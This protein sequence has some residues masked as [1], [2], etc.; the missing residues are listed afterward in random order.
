LTAPTFVNNGALSLTNGVTAAT[1][2]TINGAY[3]AQG[4]AE[5]VLN[6]NGQQANFLHIAGLA[7]GA[8]TVVAAP[9][10]N[11]P[12]LFNGL[13]PFVRDNGGGATFN[14]ANGGII[15]GG[16]SPLVT[17]AITP[18]PSNPNQYD[19]YSKVNT[20]AVAPVAGSIS[21][22]IGSVTT[23][24]FQGTTAFL[25]QPSNPTPNQIDGGV[26]TRGATGM[27][28][29]S[30]V[31]TTSLV[32]NP[33]DLQIKSHFSGYQVGSDLGMFNI[34][35]SGWNLHAGITGGEYVAST[36]GSGFVA[37]TPGSGFN[38]GW[39][40]YNVPFLGVY[41]AAT[42]HGFFADAVYRHDFWQGEVFNQN[43][44]LTNAP[45]SGGNGNSVTVE[46]GYN[47]RFQNGILN[48]ITVTPS[49]GFNYTRVTFNPLTLFP[50]VPTTSTA[51]LNLGAVESDLG[52][53]GV[54]VSDTFVTPYFALSPNATASVWHEFAGPI[55]S[56]VSVPSQFFSQT[57]SETR[58]GT[59]G[60]FSLGVTAQPLENPRWT[61]FVRADYRTGGSIYGATLTGGL[62]YQF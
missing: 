57:V 31:A 8:T 27:N 49:V 35:N 7:T 2:P 41:A 50:T 44:G 48:G 28:T 54:A 15:P 5:L 6:V 26:W 20:G 45:L 34:Q 13:I 47:Y 51:F 62:R 30:S 9:V 52:R 25:T 18:D 11:S 29:E 17:Y 32:P 1:N 23:G 56:F 38:A 19:L 55:S 36:S 40:S 58:V 24:F 59:F 21:A 46:G 61:M 42:G 43:A 4:P 53:F 10:A 12:S 14:I 22:A 60:Q 39:S 37:S 33:T 16:S 3:S